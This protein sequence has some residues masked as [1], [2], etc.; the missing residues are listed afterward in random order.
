MNTRRKN[1]KTILVTGA[2]GFTGKY[3]TKIFEKNGYDVVGMVQS[4]AKKNEVACELSSEK[5]VENA[6][7]KIKPN[8]IIHL[9]AISFVGHKNELDFYKVN[10]FGT[11]NLLNALDKSNINLDKIVIASSA[12]VYGN[13]KV[14]VLK[15][16]SEVSPVNHYAISKLSMEYMTKMWFNKFNII[17]TRPFNYT[18]VGQDKNFLIPKIIN[19]YQE[20]KKVIELGNLDV[21][22]DFSDVRDIARMYFELYESK[23]NS[24]IVNLCSGQVYKL[25]DILNMMD[26]IAGYKI[27]VKINKKFVRKNEIRVL[28]GD[29]SK[30]KQMIGT[31]STINLFETLKDMYY[32][33]ECL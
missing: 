29:D 5:S 9:A 19:H 22:R 13:P 25:R 14:N 7:S 23:H 26:E 15:E 2:S 32:E 11:L 24:E 1:K 30:L 33:K 10:L 18:G 31:S 6:L 17:I 21:A 12:N 3:V 8:G 28:K 4:N 16:N 20:N 27:K